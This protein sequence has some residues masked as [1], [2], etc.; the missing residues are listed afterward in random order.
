MVFWNPHLAARR[1]GSGVA[2]P[3][4]E[5]LAQKPVITFPIEFEP[6]TSTWDIGQDLIVLFEM[7]GYTYVFGLPP[8]A[9]VAAHEYR[10]VVGIGIST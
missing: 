7:V 6:G 5:S 10:T 9:T 8:L 3:V 1:S 2:R 4:A